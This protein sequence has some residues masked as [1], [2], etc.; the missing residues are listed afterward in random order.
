[1]KYFD[2]H[3]EV[4]EKTPTLEESPPSREN[5]SYLRKCSLCLS[6]IISFYQRPRRCSEMAAV[7]TIEKEGIKLS[8]RRGPLKGK[9]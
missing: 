7:L 1:M 4:G 2:Q 6:I 8:G 3:G 5:A 9:E